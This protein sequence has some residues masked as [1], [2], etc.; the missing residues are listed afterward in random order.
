MIE[1][2]AYCLKAGNLKNM[3]L[4]T[5]NLPDPAA[6]EV[7]ISVKAIGLNFADIFAMFGLY[8]ATPKGIFTPG[9]EYSGVVEKVGEKVTGFKPGDNI[10]GVTRFGAYTT[11]LNIGYQHI[12]PLPEAWSFAEG[13]GFL[14]Q[15]L[16]A[17]YGLFHLGHLQK[18][19]TVLIHSAAGGVGILANRLAK[20][21]GAYTIGTVGNASKVAF[22]KEEGYDEVIVRSNQ[23]AGDLAKSLNGRELNVVMECI[24]GKIFKAGFKQMAPQGRM[25][26][27]G[28]AQYA[29]PGK[30][31]NYLKAI[32]YFLTRPMI[33]AQGLA[34]ENKMVSGFNLIYLYEKVELMQQLLQEIADLEIKKPHI[35][36]TFKFEELIKAI[37]LFQTGKTI[38]K[39]VVEV[40]A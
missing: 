28:A 13:A 40:D 5:E 11:H 2:K 3:K 23:F 32:Y 24:G 37:E 8:S 7:T 22:C 20:K 39:V 31:P 4:V 1:R 33:D 10:M 6:E 21:Y 30:R 27:Y 14:V 17:H 36:H 34:E 38:G 29:S 25:V 18:E 12:I 26:V 9:L 16:T 15:V 19:E 35:G